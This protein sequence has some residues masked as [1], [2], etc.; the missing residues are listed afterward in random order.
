MDRNKIKGAA[1]LD[2]KL[3]SL[4]WGMGHC[5]KD[6]TV[7]DY[8]NLMEYLSSVAQ[9]TVKEVIMYEAEKDRIELEHKIAEL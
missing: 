6:N 4:E 5:R 8:Q 3:D 7:M 2:A 9:A 1:E